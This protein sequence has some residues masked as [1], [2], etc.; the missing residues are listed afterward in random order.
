[1][2]DDNAWVIVGRFG[3]PHGIK[4]LISVISFTEPYD[5]IIQY[6]N[7]HACIKQQWQPLRILRTE[8]NNKGI[9]AQIEGYVEREDVAQL[10]NV[11][12][13]VHHQQLKELEPGEYYWHQLMGMQV[14]NQEQVMMGTVLEIMPTGANDVLVVVGE[15]RHLIPYLPGHSIL[16][17]DEQEKIIHVDWPV[18]F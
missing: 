15:K 7:W 5:N 2:T 12:I 1:M 9:L 13:G 18:E 4:G 8:I 16:N 17:V 14:I 11:D 6:T 3:R 10:T